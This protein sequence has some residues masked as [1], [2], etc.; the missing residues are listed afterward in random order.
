MKKMVNGVV[1]NLTAEELTAVQVLE[2]AWTAG[3]S[4]RDYDDAVALRR[5]R[6]VSEADLLMHEWKFELEDGAKG[7]PE[8]AA[9]RLAWI[10][11][12]KQIKAEVPLPI[13]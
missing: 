7:G 4:Q 8:I 3:Q 5:S 2:D 13:V 9:L 1:R 10:N 12:V 11:K 6:Y